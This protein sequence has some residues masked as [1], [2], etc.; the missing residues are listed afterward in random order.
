LGSHIEFKQ[1]LQAYTRLQQT[2]CYTVC[3]KNTPGTISNK[4]Q[5]IWSNIDNLWYYAES[6]LKSA[7]INTR[8]LAKCLNQR[9]AI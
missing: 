8:S 9:T 2:M 6:T 4:S 3:R 5:Q 1:R 7:L